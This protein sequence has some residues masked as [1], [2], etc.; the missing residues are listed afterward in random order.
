MRVCCTLLFKFH[1]IYHPIEPHD[2]QA[3]LEYDNNIRK[4]VVELL[5]REKGYLARRASPGTKI[6]TISIQH[7]I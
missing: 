2:T 7:R 4:T 5:V 3:D 6:S 1:N